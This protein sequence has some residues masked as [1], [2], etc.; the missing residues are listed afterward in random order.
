MPGDTSGFDTY[1]GT[2]APNPNGGGMAKFSADPTKN[3]TKKVK[4]GTR[5]VGGKGLSTA[6]SAKAQSK[7]S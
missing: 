4:F 5:K 1:R 6:P 3:A 7:K 2:F